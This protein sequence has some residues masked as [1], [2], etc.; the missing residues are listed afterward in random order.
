MPRQLAKRPRHPLGLGLQPRGTERGELMTDQLTAAELEE[1]G[2][3]AI[4]RAKV[5]SGPGA[6]RPGA[7]RGRHPGDGDHAEHAGRA[8]R[9]RRDPQAAGADPARRVRHHPRAGRR[10]GRDGRRR[11]VHRHAD[12]ADGH[13]RPLPAARRPHRLR[14][15]DAHGVP[16]RVPGRGGLPQ[17]VPR[18]HPGAGLRPR[19]AR[20]DAVPENHPHRRR[21]AGHPAGLHPG[22]LRRRR[23]GKQPGQRGDPAR[24]GLGHADRRPASMY[25]CWQKAGQTL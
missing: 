3:V 13:R 1:I 18:R 9:R 20:P 17:A 19:P 5:R 7:G 25:N 23:P 8:A 12:P 15:H 16:G 22:R 24:P 10:P 14:L 11:R 21:L 4:I 2:L 6:R